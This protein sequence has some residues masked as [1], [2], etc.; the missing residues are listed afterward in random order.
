MSEYTVRY[1]I[2]T[3]HQPR[4][5]E[6]GWDL[7]NQITPKCLIRRPWRMLQYVLTCAIRRALE[8]DNFEIKCNFMCLREITFYFKNS[9]SYR[10]EISDIH[11]VCHYAQVDI[12]HLLTSQKISKDVIWNYTVHRSW[13]IHIWPIPFV[14]AVTRLSCTKS[15]GPKWRRNCVVQSDILRRLRGMGKS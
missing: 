8:W 1:L 13:V 9:L 14:E 10:L 5:I 12:F 4:G 7:I 11:Q 15:M 2:W 6:S 3:N